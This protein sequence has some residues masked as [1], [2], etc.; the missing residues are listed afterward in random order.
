MENPME[1]PWSL[2]LA[3]EIKF[4]TNTETYGFQL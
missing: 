1:N 4:Q 3:F 2:R